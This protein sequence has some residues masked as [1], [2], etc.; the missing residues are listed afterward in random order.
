MRGLSHTGI[1]HKAILWVV[2]NGRKSRHDAG[3]LIKM[4][5]KIFS[6]S[7]YNS[8]PRWVYG[9]RKG[10]SEV[11]RAFFESGAV[12]SQ[13]QIPLSERP[14]TFVTSFSLIQKWYGQAEGNLAEVGNSLAEDGGPLRKELHTEL[15]WLMEDAIG[16]MKLCSQE[17]D[18]IWKPA[19]WDQ[20]ASELSGADVDDQVGQVK[21][22][23]SLL[24]LG[25]IHHH[26]RDK[27]FLN[28]RN[29]K[30]I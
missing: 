29:G 3:I 20:I 21:L 28:F 27:K 25:T 22:R 8:A 9:D 30:N 11:P 10:S 16:L 26:H 7:L 14:A 17:D 6:K 23:I 1:V 19:K 4:K 15:D 12:D 24:Q 5:H 18:D 2:G 13:P